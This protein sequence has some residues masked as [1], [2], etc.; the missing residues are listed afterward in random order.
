METEYQAGDIG[1]IA[2]AYSNL[3]TE[4][5]GLVKGHK[6]IGNK[7]SR[8]RRKIARRTTGAKGCPFLAGFLQVAHLM[9]LRHLFKVSK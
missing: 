9:F 1:D 8:R 3:K 7:K 5:V 6:K 4:D 2:S